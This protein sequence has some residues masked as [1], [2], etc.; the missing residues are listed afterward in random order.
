M[1]FAHVSHDV[2]EQV[3]AHALGVEHSQTDRPPWPSEMSSQ[4]MSSSLDGSEQKNHERLVSGASSSESMKHAPRL[5]TSGAILRAASDLR[6]LR[7]SMA[8][9]DVDRLLVGAGDAVPVAGCMTSEEKDAD[10]MDS[11]VRGLKL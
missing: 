9:I 11:M 7:E 1:G 8:I 3:M 6:W 2:P 4:L 5:L 10:A